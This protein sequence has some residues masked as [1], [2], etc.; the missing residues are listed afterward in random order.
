MTSH[1]GLAAHTEGT[2][3]SLPFVRAVRSSVGGD[4]AAT[5]GVTGMGVRAGVGGSAARAAVKTTARSAPKTFSM[6]RLV[7]LRHP[8][9]EAQ[10]L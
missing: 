4:H 9:R 7:L 6:L 10:A 5:V 3:G 8:H 1:D 2:A